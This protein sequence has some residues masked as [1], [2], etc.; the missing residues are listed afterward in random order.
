MAIVAVK[1]KNLAKEV[2]ILRSNTYDLTILI[3]GDL[4]SVASKLHV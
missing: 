1:R 2:D 3:A 4:L